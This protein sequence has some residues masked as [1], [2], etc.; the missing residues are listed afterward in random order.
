M[1]EPQWQV[2]TIVSGAGK[3]EIL[4]GLLLAQEI[5]VV[6]SQEGLGDS[7]YPVSIG[8]LSEIQVLVRSH[9]LDTARQVLAEYDLE[10]YNFLDEE[11]DA[12][13]SAEQDETVD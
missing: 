1:S 5:D 3:A 9:Q 8:P 12:A 2:L 4:K 6:L 10:E 7:V 11:D 13:D